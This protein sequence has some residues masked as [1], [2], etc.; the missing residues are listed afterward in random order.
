VYIFNISICI[1]IIVIY[2]LVI[3][4]LN[5]YPVLICMCDIASDEQ[6]DCIQEK[7][8]GCVDVPSYSH[9]PVGEDWDSG[10]VILLLLAQLLYLH[11][12]SKMHQL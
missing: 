9:V 12:V 1:C 2:Q 3:Y 10:T 6:Y 4:K 7:P 5:W 11:S 8:T